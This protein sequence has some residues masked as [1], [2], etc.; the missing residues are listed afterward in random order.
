MAYN[1]KIDSFGGCCGCCDGCKY[2][3]MCTDYETED[4][5]VI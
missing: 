1:D 4:E 3:A 2:G 5:D